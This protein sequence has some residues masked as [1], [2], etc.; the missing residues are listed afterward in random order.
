VLPAHGRQERWLEHWSRPIPSGRYAGGRIDHYVDI[1]SRVL[2][3]AGATRPSS[4]DPG[5]AEEGS[6]P[7]ATPGDEIS[8]NVKPVLRGYLT[9]LQEAAIAALDPQERSTALLRRLAQ[10]VQ[11]L[12]Q[13]IL[14]NLEVIDRGHAKPE[15]LGVPAA[16]DTVV[17]L[18]RDFAE[19][20]RISVRVAADA[21]TPAIR[22]DRALVVS[23]LAAAVR[24]SIDAL[25]EG[26]CV[27]LRAERLEQPARVRISILEGPG[28][29]EPFGPLDRP[30]VPTRTGGLGLGIHL[31]RDARGRPKGI[32]QYFEMLA[33]EGEASAGPAP[34]RPHA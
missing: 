1:T 13:T 27:E 15:P 25:P 28:T 10:V 31:L 34:R 19:E 14:L 22:A 11:S 29:P 2:V 24:S 20:K 23:S 30:F 3:D 6:R 16:L 4:S 12:S 7:G 8:E 17:A 5:L 21:S 9:L 26:S 18:V 32:G 33:H